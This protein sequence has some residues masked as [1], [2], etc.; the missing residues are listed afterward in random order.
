MRD[1]VGL[2][3]IGDE[4]IRRFEIDRAR[5]ELAPWAGPGRDLW[6]SCGV[7]RFRGSGGLEERFQNARTD[8]EG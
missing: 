2:G 4:I 6:G 7:L 1:R 5:F 3:H 8:R